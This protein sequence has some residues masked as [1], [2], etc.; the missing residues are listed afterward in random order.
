V[1]PLS[2]STGK[3]CGIIFFACCAMTSFWSAACEYAT[4]RPLQAKLDAAYISCSMIVSAVA[5]VLCR[6][7]LPL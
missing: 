5:V 3:V 6:H 1:P 7:S 2:E 4:G